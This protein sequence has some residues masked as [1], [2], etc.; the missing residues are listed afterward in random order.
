[1]QIA[2]VGM[3][4]AVGV[5]AFVAWLAFM[6]RQDKAHRMAVVEATYERTRSHRDAARSAR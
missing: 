5:V 3:G 1:M 2:I 4:F 6:L